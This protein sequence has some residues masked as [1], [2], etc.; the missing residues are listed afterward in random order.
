MHKL[1][2]FVLAGQKGHFFHAARHHLKQTRSVG[3][4]RKVVGQMLGNVASLI[5]DTTKNK[6]SQV[7]LCYA[8]VQ[9]AL[10][11]AT[12]HKMGS[13][14]DHLAGGVDVDFEVQQRRPRRDTM[15]G[16]IDKDKSGSISEQEF[17]EYISKHAV[18]L[19]AEAIKALFDDASRN[20]LS[21]STF[22]ALPPM[23]LKATGTVLPQ[24]STTLRARFSYLFQEM[25]KLPDPKQG[26]GNI[27]SVSNR[28]AAGRSLLSAPS[29]SLL[30]AAHGDPWATNI[31]SC[32]SRC[33][34]CFGS[35]WNCDSECY[36]WSC[37]LGSYNA[38]G[39]CTECSTAACP[40]G[41]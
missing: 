21:H 33:D 29:R 7:I 38:N 5:S 17:D 13:M 35:C 26:V 19:E 10:S 41:Q 4:F 40:E 37:R 1:N 3:I 30:A 23:Y 34:N 24:M 11:T 22:L 8:E 18:E 14:I 36:S 9:S 28:R 15:F 25:D 31:Y 16:I 20:E 12:T 27:S 32:D 39:G 6:S 2:K